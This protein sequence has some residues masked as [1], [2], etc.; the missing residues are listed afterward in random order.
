M[1]IKFYSKYVSFQ[2]FLLILVVCCFRD[3]CFLVFVFRWIVCLGLL[4]LGGVFLCCFF[5]DAAVELLACK[6]NNLV[7]VWCDV[8]YILCWET[9]PP[10]DERLV[11]CICWLRFLL[12]CLLL[13]FV[14]RCFCFFAVFCW[15]SL[16][17]FGLFVVVF[18]SDL[19]I[20]FYMLFICFLWVFICFSNRRVFSFV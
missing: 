17:C 12:F 15:L 8:C 4:F 18:S 1:M 20:C 13:F 9:W 14:F 3:F 19:F 16:L 2:L 6:K 5:L 11:C 7:F 10:P